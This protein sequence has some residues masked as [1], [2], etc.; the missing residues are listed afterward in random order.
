LTHE[1]DEPV[2]ATSQRKT[3]GRASGSGRK[4]AY[5]IGAA[6]GVAFALFA[7]MF[8]PAAKSAIKGGIRVGR[9]AKKVASNVKEE[10]EDLAVEAQADLEREGGTEPINNGPTA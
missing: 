5:L 6:S 10:F 9:Y 3:A 8:R 2:S 1:Q 7:P 4:S